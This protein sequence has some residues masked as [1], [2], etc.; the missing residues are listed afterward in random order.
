MT[1]KK[2]YGCQSEQSVENF[3]LDKLGVGGYKNYCRTCQKV[4]RKIYSLKNKDKEKAYNKLYKDTHK[5]EVKE[6]SREWVKNNPE[7]V[8]ARKRR[9]YLQNRKNPKFVI[10][11]AI[12][13][14][15]RKRI[16]YK[17]SMGQL[18]EV[19]GY[20]TEELVAH[21]ESKFSYEMNWENYGSYWHIDHKRPKSWFS[22]KS[23]DD[24][25]FRSCWALSNLQPLEASINTSKQNRYES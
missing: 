3:C 21:L 19:L 16:A 18:K 11:S 5:E 8:R 24:P 7:K 25:E 2:C 14:A 6:Y 4:Q 1:T 23:I 15:I 12:T 13:G 9:Y 20:T 17:K 10:E 22:Y